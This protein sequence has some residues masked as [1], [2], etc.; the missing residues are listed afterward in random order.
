VKEAGVLLDFLGVVM[1]SSAVQGALWGASAPAWSE[2]AE[3]GQTP[4]YEAAFDAL[5]VGPGMQLL[6]A[7]CGAG[8]A[9]VL[10]TKRGAI[11]TGL[12]A[13]DGLLQVA[14]QRLPDAD[15]RQG[16]LEDLP[17]DDDAFDAVTAFN[18][19]QYATDPTNA[20]REIK[21]VAKPGARV[22]VA[23]W[24]APEQCDMRVVL[25]AIGS[26]LP[27]PPPGAGGPFALSAPGA[28]EALVAPAG[29]SSERTI[30][31]PTPYTYP[32]IDT[33]IRAQ[34]SSGPARRAIEHAGPQ[35]VRDALSAV[36]AGYCATD[37]TVQLDNV[38]RVLIARA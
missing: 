34:M 17:Y 12:D 25:Q 6:D 32:D 9:L 14:R 28:L 18:S 38:F 20:L 24:G 26:L 3:P 22:A 23:T 13:A 10:A 4:F 35:P 7:G 27:P 11:P 36:F 1:G 21:R 8:L 15:L 29:L 5:E 30:D 33:A 19:V 2:L 37:G 16:D 31:V